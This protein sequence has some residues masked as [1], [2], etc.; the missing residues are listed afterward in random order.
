MLGGRLRSRCRYD[1]S[2]SDYFERLCGV[3]Y[4]RAPVA[5]LIFDHK[6]PAEGG[7]QLI[8]IFSEVIGRSLC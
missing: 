5:E 4:H 2:V 7:T 1:D 8:R 3:D 6:S